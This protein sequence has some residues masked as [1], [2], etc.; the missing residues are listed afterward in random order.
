[1]KEVDKRVFPDKEGDPN[2]Q[3]PKKEPFFKRLRTFCLHPTVWRLVVLALAVASTVL[4]GGA[5]IPVV[6]LAA[7][8]IT[9]LISVIGKT[10][11]HR[12]LERAKFQNGLT[13]AIETREKEIQGLRKSHSH[14]FSVLEKE[15]KPFARAKELHEI[16]NIKPEHRGWSVA[17]V[18]SFIGLEQ[19]W[20]VALFST[21]ANPI[22]IG[23]YTAGLLLGTTV[24]KSEYDYRV[25]EEQERSRLKQEI[26][27]RCKM[28]GITK[29]ANEKD[30]YNQFEDRMINY[31]AVEMLCKEN[32]SKLS[33][34][35]IL[36]RFE[37]IRTE[38]KSTMEF[39]NI[40]KK[41]SLG[42]NLLNAINPFKE[43]NAVRTF[44]I[45]FDAS[46]THVKMPDRYE[47]IKVLDKTHGVQQGVSNVKEVLSD[48]ELEKAK[49]KLRGVATIYEEKEGPSVDEASQKLREV[50]TISEKVEEPSLERASQKFR[51]AASK[52]FTEEE[53]ERQE[54]KVRKSRSK[55]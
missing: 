51:D 44:D 40:P 3:S 10:I 24:V 43:E 32:T 50:S 54:Q 30:L 22:G 31:K 38:V 20:T 5:L 7:T 13:K 55:Q 9:A 53:L 36:S 27:E 19:F 49:R 42:R 12:S 14:I 23:V 11:Q 37:E 52:T 18:L 41:I 1:M 33:E 17:R 26:N 8:A 35:Q 4:T 2:N 15:G 39:T 48:K 34:E 29:Y 47:K 45:E 21:V 46:H 6:T 25:L 16:K 28:L